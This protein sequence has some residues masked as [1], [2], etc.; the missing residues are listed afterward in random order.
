MNSESILVLVLISVLQF[1]I[2]F[3]A[4]AGDCFDDPLKNNKSYDNCD[5]CYQ[6]LVNALIDTE[7]NKYYLGRTF[8]PDDSVKPVQ[9]NVTY[10]CLSKM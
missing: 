3:P 5:R 8:F 6:T 10:T 4:V 2:S 1:S 9:V 7:D